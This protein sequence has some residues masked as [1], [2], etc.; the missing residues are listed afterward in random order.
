MSATL[1]PSL[2]RPGVHFLP[3][4]PELTVPL[5]LTWRPGLSPAAA[6]V[7]EVASTHDQVV[8]AERR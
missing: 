2:T 3:F 8:A 7:V 4:D 6:R 5:Q 1:L